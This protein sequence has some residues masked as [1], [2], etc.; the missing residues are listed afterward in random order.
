[1]RLDLFPAEHEERD[2]EAMCLSWLVDVRG[3][4]RGKVE[5]HVK[6]LFATF[7]RVEAYDRAHLLADYY[8]DAP[9]DKGVLTK[10]PITMLGLYDPRTDPRTLTDRAWAARHG[11][12]A[13]DVMRLER[14]DYSGRGEHA[15]AERG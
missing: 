11:M 6:A 12:C 3:C 7:G 13:M 9:A 5:P 14:W 2:P 1:M 4:P 8:G 15:F 10:M